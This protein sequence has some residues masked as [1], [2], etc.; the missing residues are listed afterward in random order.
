MTKKKK[1]MIIVMAV[2][3]LLALSVGIFA[4]EVRNKKTDKNAEGVETVLLDNASPTDLVSEKETA[5]ETEN[6]SNTEIQTIKEDVSEDNLLGAYDEAGKNTEESANTT[7]DNKPTENITNNQAAQASQST[8]STTD[9]NTSYIAQSVGGIAGNQAAQASQSAGSTTNNNTSYM[10]QS[11]GGIAGNHAAQALQT[12][13]ATNDNNTTDT[14][15][16][17]G[18]ATNNNTTQSA[19]STTN[20]NTSQSVGSTTNNSTSQS[21]GNTG[22][23]ASQTPTTTEQSSGGNQGGN[24]GN[25]H[26]HTWEAQYRTVHHDE[27]GHYENVWRE[28]WDEPVYET[29]NFCNYCGI[30]ITATGVGLGHCTVCGP[31]YPPDHP[32]YGQFETQGS[33]YSSGHV[34]VG[35]THHEAGYEKKWVIDKKAGDDQVLDG[36]KCTTCG[37]TK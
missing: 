19:G 14:T 25:T 5:T 27:V 11:V 10:A 7:N 35:T 9:N 29:H 21:T 32:L 31:P 23:H 37:A 36:Y 13:E 6:G 33:S 1:T 15:Q 24:G 17:T 22:N 34:Q 3:L 28:A 16:A 20:N 8:G 30:D 12:A 4:M 26:Q 18:N 2:M